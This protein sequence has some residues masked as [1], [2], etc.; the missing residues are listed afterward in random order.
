MFDKRYD[1]KVA[2]VRAIRDIYP[3]EEIFVDYGRWY[4]L[5]KAPVRYRPNSSNLLNV[6]I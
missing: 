6:L 1:E 4:W 5:K 3:G 2:Y